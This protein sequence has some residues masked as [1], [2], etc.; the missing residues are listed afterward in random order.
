MRKFNFLGTCP[1]LVASVKTRL[2]APWSEG[3]DER[4]RLE[5]EA[6]AR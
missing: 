2:V 6:G 1:A 3:P 5:E 4:V